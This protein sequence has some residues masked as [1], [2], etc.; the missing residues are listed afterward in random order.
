MKCFL[1][2]GGSELIKIFIVSHG[3]LSL[4]ILDSVK[5]I[6]GDI[7]N[8]EALHLKRGGN[9]RELASKIEAEVKYNSSDDYIIFTD[10]KGGSVHNA[11]ISL[12]KYDNVSIIAG[13]NLGMILET[14]FITN[15]N[16]INKTTQELINIGKENIELFNKEILK[17]TLEQGDDD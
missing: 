8:I 7:K 11:M 3:N 2:K 1:Q 14:V 9:P 10:L 17:K 13:F 5:M 12:C 4:G 6:A 16:D 15:T